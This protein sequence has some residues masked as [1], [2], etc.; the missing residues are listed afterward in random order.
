MWCQVPFVPD[1]LPIRYRSPDGD[2][3]ISVTQ[4][5]TLAGRIDATWFTEESRWRGQMV[6]TLTEAFDRGDPL[7]VPVGLEGYLDAYASMVAIVRPVYVDTE[8]EVQD[9]RCGGRIDRVC[10]SIFGEPGMI[11]FKTGPPSSWHGLQL[12]AYNAMRPTGARYGC[13]LQ[14]NGK[15][16]LIPYEDSMDHRKFQYDLSRVRPRVIE[17][18]GSWRIAA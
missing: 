6:H 5:L 12:A 4:V 3:L 11:D 9:G 7:Q 16:K 13:Y 18:D 1:T 15:Y 8:C 14:A 10:A 17:V 2:P